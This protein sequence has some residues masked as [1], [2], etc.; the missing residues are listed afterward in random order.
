MF[1]PFEDIHYA[2]MVKWGYDPTGD[3]LEN[4]NEYKDKFKD[5]S[6]PFYDFETIIKDRF[7]HI[8]SSL[9]F[10]LSGGLDSSYIFALFLQSGSRADYEI[11]FVD[12]EEDRHYLEILLKEYKVPK[13]PILVKTESYYTDDQ[14]KSFMK[15]QGSPMDLGSMQAN[16]D[17]FL[18]AN[19]ETVVTGDGADE[20]FGGY[21]RHELYDTSSSDIE[22][23]LFYYHVPR[24]IK[25]AESQ[26][27]NLFSPYLELYGNPANK[28]NLFM[29]EKGLLKEAAKNYLPFD[30][31]NRKKTPLKSEDSKRGMEYRSKLVKLWRDENGD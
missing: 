22:D 10:F 16:A 4:K 3:F 26:G 5:E 15:M 25:M 2:R 7:L 13:K 1:K 19:K 29:Q 20:M 9:S 23:E 28:D 27:K 12:N 6:I 8:K 30:I 31:I 18:N 24:V 17:L 11:L 21:S 14:L